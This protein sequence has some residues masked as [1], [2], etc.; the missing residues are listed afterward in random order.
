[1]VSLGG[2]DVKGLRA[3]LKDRETL[4]G[5]VLTLTSTEAAEMM[6]LVGFDYLWI[7]T[8]HTPMDFT[9]AERMVQAVGGRCPCLIRIPENKEVWIK[10]AL[11]LGCDGIIVP[12]VKSKEGGPGMRSN[13]LFIL[14]WEREAWE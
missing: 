13:V 9:H 6:A 1:M 4:I 8:E 2:R 7:D 3:R 5:T 10:K 12:Q 11:D 14:L